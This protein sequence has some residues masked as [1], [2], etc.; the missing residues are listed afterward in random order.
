MTDVFKI[1][2]HKLIYHPHE[3]SEWLN[4]SP[5]APIYVE[6]GLYGGC[7]HRCKFCA[8]SNRNYSPVSIEID[9]L[10]LTITSLSELGTKSIM[11]SGE[12]EPL[13]YKSIQK[14][15]NHTRAAGIDLSITTNGV[16]LTESFIEQ[17]LDKI[18]WIKV[19]IDAGTSATYQQI[20]GAKKGDFE[21]VLSNLSYA[22]RWRDSKNIDCTIGAQMLLMKENFTE[23][24]KLAHL[25]E[26]VGVDYLVVKPFSPHPM[27]NTI[28]TPIFSDKAFN[29]LREKV[30]RTTKMNIIFRNLAFEA[31]NSEKK[32]K[33]C[34]ALDFWTLIDEHGDVY[35]CHHFL[36]NPEHIY[37]NIHKLDFKD[38]W[39]NRKMLEIDVSKCRKA[40]RMDRVNEYL[41]NLKHPPKHVNFI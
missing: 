22:I 24:S 17:C 15:V 28:D 29:D 18:S 37:G 40:C 19:S 33:N 14:A 2:G 20:H 39:Q 38:I 7:N 11:F 12:G 5:V 25:L 32:Y 27:N 13:L 21:T 9:R 41:W 26:S 6:I 34:Y 16:K 8:Y 4:D 1:D 3:V 36:K 10:L 30:I 31:L 35:S 23:V